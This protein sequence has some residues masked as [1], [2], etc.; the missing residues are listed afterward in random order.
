MLKRKIVAFVMAFVMVFGSIGFVPIRVS[1]AG[2]KLVKK[3]VVEQTA[4]NMEE[5]ES[6]N[7][8]YKVTVT[9]GTSKKVQVKVS[10]KK[11]I[12][13]KVS[14]KKIVVKAKKEGRST[15]TVMTK[16]KNKNGKRIAKKIQVVV[17]HANYDDEELEYDF[18]DNEVYEDDETTAT[19]AETTEAPTTGAPTEQ[20]V[21]TETPAQTEKKAEQTTPKKQEETI[22]SVTYQ[23]HVQ[24]T[25]WMAN[26]KDGSVA[27]TTGKSKRI[28]G[29]KVFLTDS[30]GTSMIKYRAHVGNVGWQDWKTSGQAAGTEKQSKRMEAIQIQL[31][32]AYAT[33]YDIYYSVHLANFGWLGWAKNGETAGSEGLSLQ[34]EAIKIRLVKKNEAFSVGGRHAIVAPKLTYQAHCMNIGWKNAVSAGNIVGTVGEKRQLEALKINL[35]DTNGKSGIEYRAHVS[36]VG[37]QAWKNSGE[38][39]GTTGQSRKLEA[40]EIKLKGNIAKDFD[41]YYRVHVADIGWMGWAK[42]GETAGTTGGGRQAEAVQ[43]ILAG[44]GAVIDRGGAA[45][46]KLD[47][48]AKTLPINWLLINS[49]G[50]QPSGSDACGC[51]ALAYSRTILDGRIRRWNEFDAHGGGNVKNTLASWGAANYNSNFASNE[52][53]VYQ[54]AVAS[55]NAGKPMVV[56]VHGTRS[57]RGHYVAIV[58]Y[59]NVTDINNLSANNFLIIDSGGGVYGCTENLG[60]VGYSLQKTSSGYQY[61]TSR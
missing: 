54:Q 12:S 27:G 7:V 24:D 39:A 1:A 3:L 47:T 6:E 2:K 32:G 59:T 57:S 16:A 52:S 58:G 30:K 18:E 33:K 25:G 53:T 26:V 37:W 22:P 56:R 23:A 44:K 5:G 42:N 14:G 20:A 11:V 10:N 34:A 31:T 41:I 45:Y 38:I 51:Y 55:I 13:A 19:T 61:C 4:L 46:R 36:Y 40:I 29:L 60:G 21:T 49:V 48:S 50:K 8:K 9:K 35:A 17:K 43:I 15:I 28:E